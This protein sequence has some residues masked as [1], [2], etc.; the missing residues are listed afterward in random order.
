MKSLHLSDDAFKRELP[1]EV[2]AVR[3]HIRGAGI[4][5][6]AYYS[7]TID[8]FR[9]Q[10]FEGGRDEYGSDA[11]HIIFSGTD[12][13]LLLHEEKYNLDLSDPNC[14]DK[15]IG[16]LKKERHRQEDENADR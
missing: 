4:K 3:E 1:D 5:A 9:V 10:V 6:S 12:L 11:V 13:E 15:L 14:F 8:K 7:H 2:W 16:I